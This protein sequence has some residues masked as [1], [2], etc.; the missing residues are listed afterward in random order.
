MNTHFVVEI[1]RISVC[2]TQQDTAFIQQI[3]K[4]CGQNAE[5]P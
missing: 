3:N 1:L 5:F 4:N 2:S